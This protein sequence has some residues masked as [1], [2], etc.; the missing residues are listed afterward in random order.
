EDQFR[1]LPA[2]A[3]TIGRLDQTWAAVRLLE[4]APYR[5]IVRGMGFR[6][7]VS[8]WPAW[9]RPIP[10]GSRRGG[11]GF[12]VG[13]RSATIPSLSSD[14]RHASRPRL[15]S[16]TSLP[17]AG[18]DTCPNHVDCRAAAPD[19]VTG[20]RQA[21]FLLRARLERHPVARPVRDPEEAVFAA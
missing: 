4:Y 10:S 1:R 21:V 8:G 14:P 16:G 12:L 5:E 17:D 19:F 9:R 20:L 13:W 15:V 7:L 11:G 2:G 18:P 6:A 3:L